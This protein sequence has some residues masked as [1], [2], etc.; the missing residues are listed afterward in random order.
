M[1]AP[2]NSHATSDSKATRAY[3]LLR[4]RLVLHDIEPGEA[5]NELA[6]AAE[7]GLG[8]TPIREALKRLENDRLVVSYPRRG[9]FATNIDIKDLAMISEMRIVLE[10][11]AARKAANRR[12][13][14]L[15]AE[16]EAM[17]KRLR[18]A[19]VND[20]PR[21]MLERDHDVHHLVYGAAD[22]HL[23]A[24]TL[25]RLDNLAT[26][27]WGLVRDRIPDLDNQAT[28]HIELLTAILDGDADRAASLAAAHVEDFER[29][30]R[31]VL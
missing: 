15:R 31:S 7:F 3:E 10:P 20:S 24:D 29:N 11:I 21:T 28:E 14:D 2:S 12:G 17:I 25:T 26:R 8:R 13:G 19:D 22:N 30:V 23:L 27:L 5:I 16:Y 18:A 1:S 4:Q 9:T 6:L